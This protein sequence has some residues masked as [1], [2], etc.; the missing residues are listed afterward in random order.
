VLR[1]WSVARLAA[2][3]LVVPADETDV[4]E[5]ASDVAGGAGGVILFGTSAPA[6]MGAA[7]AQL[8]ATA[9]GGIRPFV[10][11]D[12][13]GGFVQRMA[14]VTGGLPSA[15]QMG[16]TMT[17]AQIQSLA[18]Q[19]GQKLRAVGV[20]MDLAPVLDLDDGSG[21]NAHDAIGT[22]SFS[23]TEATAAADGTAFAKGLRAAGIVPVVKHFPGLGGSPGNTDLAPAPTRP[24]SELQANDLLAFRA[25]VRAGLPAVMVANATVP[26]LTALPASVSPSV[27]TTVLRNQLGFHGLVL[28]DSLSAG[29]ISAAGYSVP[30]AAVQALRSGA[31]LLL[32]GGGPGSARPDIDDAIGAITAAVGSGQLSRARLTEAVTH[33][34]TAKHATLCP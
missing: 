26:G 32:L 16:A 24:W 28:T 9:P 11:T 25:A 22:R 33:I 14:N 12:E 7:L 1:T 19:A 18:K 21:P 2:Q 8:V 31:D 3:T 5:A 20:T 13:E 15:R 34:L 29:A 4:G 6:G 17:A 27:I 10:M 30:A 23:L